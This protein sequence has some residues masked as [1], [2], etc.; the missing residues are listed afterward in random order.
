MNIQLY[1]LIWCIMQIPILQTTDVCTRFEV[2]PNAW[3]NNTVLA[4][5]TVRNNAQCAMK[6]SKHASCDF[7]SVGYAQNETH[8][9]CLMHQAASFGASP[10]NLVPRPNWSVLATDLCV[11]TTCF[12]GARCLFAP[13]D[14]ST[15]SFAC[16][17]PST[18]TGQFCEIECDIV[19][20]SCFVFYNQQ[21]NWHEAVSSCADQGGHIAEVKNAF[22]SGRMKVTSARG[23]I[24]I[25]AVQQD[26]GVWVWVTSGEEVTWTDWAPGEPSSPHGCAAFVRRR[27]W[28]DEMCDARYKYFCEFF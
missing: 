2:L 14:S 22:V 12:N 15:F 8:M 1:S 6:C 7:A 25:G 13:D 10:P 17:C 28:D 18:H 11:F 9:Q 19:D 23:N 5:V 27:G 16:E 20:G 21:L 3:L 4:Y 26:E 24:W